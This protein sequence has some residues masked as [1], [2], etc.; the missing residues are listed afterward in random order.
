MQSELSA[1]KKARFCIY[2]ASLYLFSLMIGWFTLHPPNYNS[3]K[4]VSF[5]TKKTY[6]ANG[7]SPNLI[8][9]YPIRILIPD[10]SYQGKVVDLPIDK[11]FYDAATDSWTLSGYHA[12]FMT[13]S[14]IANNFSGETFIYGHNNNYVFGALRHNTPLPGSTALIYTDNGHIFSYKFVRDTNVAPDT[15]SV[16]EYHGPPIL[17]IQT[18]TGSFNQVRTLYTYDFERVVQ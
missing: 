1:I 3:T 2:V 4:Y 16:L 18:C 11:G 14:A 5:K 17:T 7:P 8:N 13:I 15:T 9:G 10:S 12:Q 6:I